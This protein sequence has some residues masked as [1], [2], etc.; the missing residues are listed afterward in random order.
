MTS[1]IQDNERSYAIDLI[2]LINDILNQN[3]LSI[4]KAGGERT[5]LDRKNRMFPDLVLYSDSDRISI[6]QGW[7]LKLPDTP[8]TDETFIK[9]AQRKAI[10]LGLNSCFIWNFTSGVLYTR[11]S[12]CSFS[13]KKQWNLTSNIKTRKDVQIYRK[14]WEVSIREIIIELNQFFQNG[15]ILTANLG[16]II[17]DSVVSSIIKRNN[18]LVSSSLKDLAFTNAR[19]GA[20]LT[21]WWNNAQY[22]FSSN[23][24]NQYDEYAKVILLHWANRFVFAHLIKKYHTYANKVIQISLRY[25]PKDANDIFDDITKHCD[26]FNIFSNIDYNYNLP[27]QTWLDFIELN[28]FLSENGISNI[29]QTTLQ[30]ILETSVSTAKREY[31]GQFTTPS[32]LAEILARITIIN[33][34]S[35]CID[36][37]C[38]TG[39]IPLEILKQKKKNLNIQDAVQTTW[40]SDKFEYPLQIANIS[41][42]SP[43]SINIPNRI[44]KQNALSY[45]PNTIIKI[46]NP[47]NGKIIDIELPYFG[48]IIS[49]LPFVAFESR[50]EDDKVFVKEIIKRIYNDC[51]ITLSDRSDLYCFI[52]LALKKIL[53][54]DGRLGVITSNSWL[55]TTWGR[56]FFKVLN[57]YFKI[58]QIHISGNGRWFSNADVVTVIIILTNKEGFSIPVPLDEISFCK[59]NKTL[60]DISAPE[61]SQKKENIIS[62]S[63]LNK[64]LHSD[65]LSICK[66]S[67]SQINELL[68]YNVSLNSMFHSAAWLLE[69]K[70]KLIPITT[71]FNVFRG[72]RRGWDAM[73]YPEKDNGIEKKC[74]RKVL[75]NSR[76]IQSLYARADSDAFCCSY[77]IEELTSEKLKGAIN[78]IN[79]F[80][81]L[82][83]EKGKLLPEVLKRSNM[84][85][86]EMKDSSCADLCLTMNPDRRLFFA[87]F[88]VPTFINQRLIGLKSK[89]KGE[90]I[91]LLHALLNSILG[92]YYIEAIGF[93]RG[94]G[95]LDI[96]KESL[97]NA[98]MLNPSLISDRYKKSIK[99]KFKR[100]SGRVQKTTEEELKLADRLNF[101]HEVLK[102]FGIDKYFSLIK[103]SLLS[104]QKTRLSANPRDTR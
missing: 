36:P 25:S 76:N 86:Y 82:C 29:E 78:W 39:S 79:K 88:P 48:S 42:T 12:T 51:K 93:G 53:A 104:M 46:T 10:A 47:K 89:N 94:L 13:I 49:N 28:Q 40:A 30:T 20:F 18:N 55:G 103:N 98:F 26:F 31:A 91:S 102:A 52:I 16:E 1:R 77:S 62:S 27:D 75:K 70:D 45:I 50:S 35:D 37:C 32:N 4:K 21:E 80:K 33:W 85:W 92:M 17:S 100:F 63:L 99:A 19:V 96:N 8:I 59:W 90:D 2:S 9:D 84:H 97:K 34:K 68:N 43:S 15:D 22:D 72:E 67:Q 24:T 83:N 14:E 41:I 64:E 38:G 73:F 60:L 57:M 71:F 69:I 61:N 11:D 44:F 101:E 66:Y 23:A 56:E 5:I 58:N 3:N 87:K 54:K 95:V 74:L 81:N 6:V 7:E 65:E